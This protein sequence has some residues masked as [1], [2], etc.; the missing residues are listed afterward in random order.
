[1]SFYFIKTPKIV[2]FYYNKYI[3][4]NKAEKKEIYITFD[5]G[6]TPEVTPFVLDT[7]KEYGVKATFFCL[8]KNIEKHSRLFNRIIEE[9]HTVGNHT[10]NHLNGWKTKT[11]KYID[12]VEKCQ[13]I[14]NT[15]TERKS[16][17][18][19]LFRPPYGRI[20][21][22]QGRR[23]LNKGYKI[24]MWSVL[25]ADFDIKIT[26][27]KCLE[28]VIKNTKKGDIIVFHDS[29]K[30]FERLRYVLPKTLEFFK[31]KNILA[32]KM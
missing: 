21:V 23:L 18:I 27:E 5:D 9:G 11:E 16:G 7:L 2:T 14:I 4:N 29:K 28:N 1:M 26:K 8:G 20:K 24:I 12:N 25:S 3:W 31:E 10:Q 32:N 22:K 13:K 17:K 19:K 30:A 6:P 15:K